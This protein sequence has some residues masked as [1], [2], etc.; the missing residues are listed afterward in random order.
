[1]LVYID[2]IA[3]WYDRS[4]SAHS[5]RSVA[6]V[7]LTILRSAIPVSYDE[8]CGK[9]LANVSHLIRKMGGGAQAPTLYFVLPSI[10]P[11]TNHR[12]AARKAMMSG[13]R[14]MVAPAM[15]GP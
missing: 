1:M 9:S 2:V 13:A 3:F 10:N 15:R 7:G 11:S 14:M 5:P 12:C 4:P 8:R 6:E